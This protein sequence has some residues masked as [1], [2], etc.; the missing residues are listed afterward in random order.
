MNVVMLIGRLTK[1]IEVKSTPSGKAVTSF[2]LAVDR[3][4]RQD[5]ADFVNC[6]AWGNTA[7][8]M[9]R[10]LSKGRKVALTGRISVR[11]Y[12]TRDKKRQYV[13]EVVADQVEFLDRAE[14]RPKPVETVPVEPVEHEEFVDI[15]GDGEELPF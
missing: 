6:V 4:N 8:A 15:D 10:Y 11:S 7:E 12:E 2:T 5:G 13:T 14:E 1:D 9:G 3:R